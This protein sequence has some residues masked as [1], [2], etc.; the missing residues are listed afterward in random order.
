MPN[1]WIGVILLILGFFF[2]LTR[3]GKALA[4]LYALIFIIRLGFSYFTSLPEVKAGNLD[5]VKNFIIFWILELVKYYLPP[6]IGYL[7]GDSLSMKS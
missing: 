1:I 4:A 2:G 3:A 7:A 5:T 6:G